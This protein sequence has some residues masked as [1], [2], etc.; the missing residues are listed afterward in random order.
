MILDELLVGPADGRDTRAQRASSSASVVT[1]TVNG[2]IA[3][4]PA[5]VSVGADM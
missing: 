4:V 2:R 5:E 3:A 1:G